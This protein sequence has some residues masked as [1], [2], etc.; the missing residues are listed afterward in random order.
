M[1]YTLKKTVAEILALPRWELESWRFLFD[2]YG[3]LD[4]K[5]SDF[6]AARANQFA[7]ASEL[8]L[9]DFLLFGDPSYKEDP[10]EARAR[11][12]SKLLEAF[13]YSQ[14]EE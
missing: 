12:E 8:P 5:R 14:E 9:K 3:P 6:L 2:I 4:W 11:R 1:A 7:S 10:E 13:G